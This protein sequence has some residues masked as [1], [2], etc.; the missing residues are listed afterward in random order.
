MTGEEFMELW[1]DTELRGHL[2]KVCKAFTKNMTIQE[3]LLQ[4]AWLRISQ[5]DAHKHSDYYKS[6]GFKS[7]D[8]SYRKEWRAWRL[9]RW[10][11]K[12]DALR[13]RVRYAEE[14][15]QDQISENNQ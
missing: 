4:D 11:K 3:D 2:I 14:K 7:M 9:T 15:Y 5:C 12:H 13:K 1:N 6:Q 10:G 8:N